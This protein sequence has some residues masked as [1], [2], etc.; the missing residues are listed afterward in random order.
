VIDLLHDPMPDAQRL[1]DLRAEC[2]QQRGSALA[3]LYRRPGIW[4]RS[5]GVC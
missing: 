4:L 5:P 1:Q 2:A 3:E